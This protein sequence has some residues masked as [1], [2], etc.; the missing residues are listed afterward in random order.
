MTQSTVV[1]LDIDRVSREMSQCLIGRSIFHRDVVTSTMDEARSLAESNSPEGTVV[2]AEEQTGGRGRFKRRWVTRK[3][4]DLLLSVVLRPEAALLPQVNMAATLAVSKTVADVGGLAPAIKWPN[5]VRVGGR[6]ISGILVESA[7][8]KG[9]PGHAVVGIGLNVN[10]DTSIDPEI[11]GSATSISMETGRTV[12]R[13]DVLVGLLWHMDA[14]YR[15]VVQ[16]RLLT[17]EWAAR[18]ETLGRQ[19]QVRWSDRVV[20][21]L[22]RE[23]DDQGSLVVESADGT[24][25]TV[26]AGEVTLQG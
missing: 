21:G 26:V 3:G 11:V 24:K 20:E 15:S 7:S 19:V 10:I 6:K 1:P 5:D 2:V 18:L 22:A 12:D 25:T 14:L 17:K 4:L 8:K 16:G 23:V 13:T 9:E